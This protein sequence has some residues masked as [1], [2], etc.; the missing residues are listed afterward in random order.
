[1][2]RVEFYRHALTEDDITAVAEV[3][4]SVFLTTGPRTAAFEKALAEYAGLHH[5]LG[6]TSCTTA[7]F[8]CLKAMGVGEGDEVITTPLT[9]IATANAVLHAGATPVFVDVE[10]ETGNLDVERVEAA[11]TSR[12]RVVLPVHLYGLM[13]DM[14]RL[15]EI[16]G[17]RGIPI[18]EDA[19]HALEAERDGLR[20]GHAGHAVCYSFYATK[21]LTCGE[22]GA[23]GTN[24]SVLDDAIRK[25][26]LHGMSKGAADRYVGRYQHWDMETLGY[27]ANMSDI[28]AALMLGQIPRLVAQLARREAICR[29]YEQAFREVPGLS[30]PK[31]P[32]GARSARHLFTI[33]VPPEKRDEVLWQLQ[34]QGIGVAVNY[35]AI[36]L[37]SFY[38]S[39]SGFRR[40]SFP[41]AER[42]GDSTITLPLYPSL[43]DAQVD[44][45]IDVVR[46]I[47][48]S[49]GR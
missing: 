19:A 49:W 40:G 21:N 35:R 27:K 12:T 14:R 15:G 45:V 13:A 28:Q 11:M 18:L 5:V 34:E 6:L 29:R 41:I 26:R 46:G 22:G 25:L 7:L 20:P 8:L 23:V 4:R 36:H 48:A 24:D 43:T 33:W 39:R 32:S 1:M 31:V 37:L 44:R 42:I 10:P 47:A 9:F 30:Y 3:L 2:D 17:R 38:A 16:C